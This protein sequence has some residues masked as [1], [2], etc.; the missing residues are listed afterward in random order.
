MVIRV[1]LILFMSLN[2]L[3][4]FKEAMR[5][6]QAN[7]YLQSIDSLKKVE[8]KKVRN[9]STKSLYLLARNMA[10]LKRYKE[11]IKINFFIIRKNYK[12]QDQIVRKA[13]KNKTDFDEI[14]ELEDGLKKVYLSLLYVYLS[15]YED[16]K[17]ENYK[18]LI[19]SFAELLLVQ[20]FKTEEVD[21]IVQR[22]AF[23]DKNF[24]ALKIRNKFYFGIGYSL[25][26]DQINLISPAGKDSTIYSNAQ[27]TTLYGAW[28]KGD[29]FRFWKYEFALTMAKATVG[30]D[31]ADFEYFQSNVTELLLMTNIGYMFYMSENTSAGFN[32]PILFRSGDFTQPENFEIKN[33]TILSTGFLGNLNWEMDNTFLDFK[34]GKLLKFK[35]SFMQLS[36]GF[37]F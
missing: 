28:T 36:V 35:S 9:Y 33:A 18:N 34:F 3:A 21:K 12:K 1:I 13:I 7:K 8:G 19:S 15:I 26:Q 37:K 4:S 24:E 5:Y 25:W 20:D 14:E 30:E 6:Y 2:S 17:Y 32:I 29:S 31:S 23:V 10:K 11:A 22:L 27:G 16:F